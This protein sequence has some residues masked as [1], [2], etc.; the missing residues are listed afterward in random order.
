[1]LSSGTF[2]KHFTKVWNVEVGVHNVVGHKPRGIRNSS[3][4]FDWHRCA[5]S[6][7]FGGAAPRLASVSP[8]KFKNNFI[9]AAFVVY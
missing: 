4:G 6:V 5:T 3:Y 7:R 8:Y 1:M 9:E 2:V